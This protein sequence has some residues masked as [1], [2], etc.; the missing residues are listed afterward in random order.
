MAELKFLII[1]CTATEIGRR[2]TSDEIRQWHMGAPPQG[3]GWTKVGYSDM[4]HID[5]KLEN[6]TQFDQDDN[7]DYNEMTWGVAGINSKSRHVVYV[8]GLLR[9]EPSDTRTKE[10]T[11]AL[12]TYIRYTILRHP[13]IQI[14]GHNQFANKACPCFDVPEFLKWLG[15]P[16]ANIWQGH[17]N[18][19]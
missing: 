9:G 15:I 17:N 19:T 2:V 13:E 10:Q 12:E 11:E 1:H 4:I 8:G 7:I 16:E 14:A 3:R 18:Q 5:G 6:L